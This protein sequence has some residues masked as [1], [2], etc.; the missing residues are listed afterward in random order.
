MFEWPKHKWCGRDD[1]PI[2][3]TELWKKLIK[4]IKNAGRRVE[5]YWVKGHSKDKHNRAVDKLA[6]QSAKIPLNTPPSIVTVRRKGTSKSVELGSVS[7]RGQRI[8]VKI[9]TSE[10]LNTQ[11][12]TKYKYEVISKES[13]YFGNVDIIFSKETLKA[14]HSYEVSFNK[15]RH[16]P[17]ILRVI[18]EIIKN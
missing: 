7:T 10:Y 2:L 3:N 12:L 18:R 4:L 1:R 14:G 9:I 17:R 15:N 16:N 5:F 8:S 13:R 6:K 11:K